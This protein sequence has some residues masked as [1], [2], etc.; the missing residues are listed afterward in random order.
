MSE[1][2]AALMQQD[3][4]LKESAVE[5]YRSRATV[6][7]ER[8]S[9][10]ASGDLL[11][12]RHRA[13]L[14]FV[15][16]W[17]LCAGS[18]I[19]DMGCGPGRLTHDLA[20]MGYDGLG[21]D[22]SPSMISLSKLGAASE[23]LA[24]KWDYELGD[25][26]AAP[27]PDASFDAVICSGVIDYLLSDEKLI[28]EAVRVLKPGGRFLLCFTNQFGYTVCLSTPLYWMKKVAIVRSIASSLR[29]ALVGGREGAMSF[30]FLPR[31]HRPAAAR[32]ALIQQGFKIDAD[33]YVHFSLLPAPFCAL[34]SK[35]NFGIDGK[36]EALDRTA[37]RSLGSCYILSGR[38]EK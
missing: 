22:A 26:E 23:G 21:I 37:L 4:N 17:N 2:M 11:W 33:R 3:R 14:D 18:R 16:S 28:A 30:N 6:Y 10:K 35:L 7:N 38:I 12:V 20:K 13:I 29:S 31:K 9:V 32:Q 8:Y 34:T 15:R 19:L 27:A 36:L 24:G 1:R 5:Y 25:V